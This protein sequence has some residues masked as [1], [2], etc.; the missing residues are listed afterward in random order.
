MVEVTAEAEKHIQGRRDAYKEQ[1]KEKAKGRKDQSKF[2]RT[3]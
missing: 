1:A 2:K 3:R